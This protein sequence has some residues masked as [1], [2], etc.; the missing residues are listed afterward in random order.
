MFDSRDSCSFS[1]GACPQPLKPGVL[2]LI[3]KAGSQV[4]NHTQSSRLHFPSIVLGLDKA[5]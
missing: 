4:L 2:M 1:T 5:N 3:F